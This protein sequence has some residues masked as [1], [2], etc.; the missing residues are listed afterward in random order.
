MRGLKKDRR[1]KTNLSTLSERTEPTL[2]PD[3]LEDNAA[4]KSKLRIRRVDEA[5]RLINPQGWIS[6]EPPTEAKD[7][8]QIYASKFQEQPVVESPKPVNIELMPETPTRADPDDTSERSD[9]H[10]TSDH[11]LRRRFGPDVDTQL[12]P[13]TTMT[14]ARRESLFPRTQ[15]VEF[16]PHP[17]RQPNGLQPTRRD[18]VQMNNRGSIARDS[19]GGHGGFPRA[20]T[21]DSRPAMPRTTSL[22]RVP[23]MQPERDI[24]F[25][26]FPSPYELFLRL[27]RRMFPTL[28]RRLR[29][30]LT[31]PQATTVMSARSATSGARHALDPHVARP[32]PYLS[33]DAVVRRNSAF[34][35]LSNEQLEELGGVEYRALNMLLWVIGLVRRIVC[36]AFGAHHPIVSHRHS[37]H[38][39]PHHCA[40]HIAPTVAGRLPAADAAS[41]HFTHLVKDRSCSNLRVFIK[42]C[43]VHGLPSRISVHERRHVAR[44]PVHDSLPEGIS[45]DRG[46]EHYHPSR[47]YCFRE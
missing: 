22:A 29:R 46:S 24:G 9:G 14:S 21:F 16:A 4:S 17:R 20:R 1:G 13:F 25:G 18:S 30:T 44:R 38:R 19:A 7:E 39:M 33:F 37:T 47:Q 2:P 36:A 26:G 8:D 23:S 15:T 27:L 45:Y 42:I 28:Q 43:Q 6:D 31:I 41:Y 35:M 10:S 12:R 40:V 11:P 3:E 5:P 32:V 34:D